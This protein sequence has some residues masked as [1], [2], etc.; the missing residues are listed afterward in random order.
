MATAIFHLGNNLSLRANVLG[1]G[2]Y[3]LN[4]KLVTAAYTMAA[5]DVA[6]SIFGV[7]V[8][9][10]LVSNQDAPAGGAPTYSLAVATPVTPKPAGDLAVS[11]LGVNLPVRLVKLASGN[12]YA[13]GIALQ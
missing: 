2:T 9:I 7:N 12:V 8:P 11:L 3:S 1:D 5:G 10:L 6:A 4:V 13:L